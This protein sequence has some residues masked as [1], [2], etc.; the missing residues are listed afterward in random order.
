[1][2][3]N[4]LLAI[5]LAKVKGYRIISL[6]KAYSLYPFAIIELFYLFLQINVLLR[7][8]TFIPYTAIINSIYLYTL[9]LPMLAYRLYKPGIMGSVLIV[10]G[11]SLNQF[12]MSQNGGKMPV[13]ATL[14]KITGYYDASAIQVADRIHIIGDANTKYKFL[15]DFIDVGFSVLSIG[16]ILIHCFITII[17]YYVIKEININPKYQKKQ[18]K[19]LLYG[20]NEI[21]PL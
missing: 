5:I 13:Y 15:T 19:E 2:I 9:L 12:V 3:L 14:T 6:R 20:T 16:D 4:L 10:I 7:N 8:Y 21:Y 1:M 18:E 17:I 11:T